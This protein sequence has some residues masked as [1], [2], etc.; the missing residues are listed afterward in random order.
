MRFHVLGL[1]HTVSSP[2]YNACAFTQKV[3][4]FCRMMKGRGHTLIHYGH[5][6]SV[7]DADEHVT[8]TTDEDLEIAYGNYDWKKNFF[9][10]N[11]G[12]HAHTVFNERAGKEI[13]KRKQKNDF[14]LAFWGYGVKGACD[15]N[16]DLIVV[17]PGIGYPHSFSR[18]KVYESY[19]VMHALCGVNAVAM[20]IMDWYHTVIPNYF[21]PTEF[22][23]EAEKDDYILALGR[24]TSAKGV[25]IA[26][27]ATEKTGHKLI[28]AGQGDPSN[29]GLKEWPS[30]VECIGYADIETRRKLM[31]KAKAGFIASTY[32][33]PFGGVQVE[34]H[35]S[36]TPVISS[37]W[38]AFTEVNP[39]GVTGYR[40]RTMGDFIWAINNIKNINPY[41][42][43]AWA[44]ANYSMSVIARKYEHYFQQVL[45]I[46][47]GNGWYEPH[48]DLNLEGMYGTDYTCIMANK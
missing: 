16:Q 44:N 27:Q 3:V 29:V 42:C 46:Y 6:D 25:D 17:E 7:V 35:M 26:I 21:D 41:T 23:F 31:S 38:G 22:T 36:G 8:V 1:P 12:D 18:F 11:A 40:G 4:K 45:D 13:A 47:Q 19:A 37:D 32:I 43:A 28:I 48:S 20:G 33:E 5:A 34:Y 15:A 10:H 14:I 9:K 24:I 39:H 30:H 2:E